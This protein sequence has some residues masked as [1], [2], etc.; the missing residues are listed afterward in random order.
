MPNLVNSPV[1]TDGTIALTNNSNGTVDLIADTAGYYLAGTPTE[2]G[3][4][5]SLTPFRQLD[6]RNGTGATTALAVAPWAT[7]RVRV[8]GRGGIPATGVSAVAVNVTVTSTGTAGN[9]TVYAG[10][11]AQP[12]TS[13]LNFTAGQTIPNLVNSPVGTDGT[14]ALTNNSGSTVHLI[15][16]T[17]G[18]FLAGAP[19]AGG[20]FASLTPFRQLDT[21]NGTGAASS[22]VAPWSTVRV[23]VA[24]RGG[25]PATGVSA[26]AVNVTVTN[27]GTEG[28]ITV[29]AGGTK[30]PG[31][32]NLNFTPGQTIPNLVNSPVGTD[33]TIALTNNSGSTIHLIADTAGYYLAGAPSDSVYAWG[34]N[35]YGQLG[36]GSRVSSTVPVQVAGLSGAVSVHGAGSTR[37]AILKD[38]TVK[39]WGFGTSGQLGSGGA[40]SS[41]VPVQ[42]S[43][44]T[45]VQDLS[46]DGNSTY[47]LLKDGTVR[48]WGIN[49]LGELGI[50][51]RQD[52]W[53]P[54]EIPGL[55]GVVSISAGTYGPL[56]LLEDGT[57]RAWG[58]N[59]FGQLG[60]GTT[61]D[62]R[63]PVQV[64]GLTGVKA[65]Y[66]AGLRSLALLEDGTVR[67]WGSNA[68]GELGNGT[69]TDSTLPVQVLGLTGVQKLS[70]DGH[71][72]ALLDDGTVRTW[73]YNANG[74]L[75]NGTTT[76]SSIPVTVT[77][78]ADVKDIS[79]EGGTS[80][81]LL[82]DG[83]STRLGLKLVRGT[84]L[85]A[86]TSPRTGGGC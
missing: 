34:S 30:Q 36:I 66:K 9:I 28:N 17:A 49:G 23:K 8:T 11:T 57:V 50:G 38:G 68:N 6:T 47:A 79:C 78:L 32:S 27:P 18:Y 65:V 73:G 7:V 26:V 40:S 63:T 71:T 70:S 52:S 62:S 15:A 35:E 67:A 14:I 48:A 41:S 5:T 4:F 37:Y 22:T 51:A 58:S 39:A 42:V 53:V 85:R 13:N 60:N 64:T 2:A 59:R 84:D 33:G 25:I 31:T 21:R 72:C 12:G 69:T 16:E 61:T 45:N 86:G 20:I 24:G 43:A 29:Y 54:V 3:A 19:T 44:L 82:N 75:G 83:H 46:T 76:S 1:G 10:G 80:L 74:E 56:A 81:A 55:A 77:G